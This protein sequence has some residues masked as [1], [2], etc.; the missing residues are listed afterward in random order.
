MSAQKRRRWGIGVI[1]KGIKK[2]WQMLV[3]FFFP[4]YS[5]GKP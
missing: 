1:K 2:E 4:N 3:P 5:A